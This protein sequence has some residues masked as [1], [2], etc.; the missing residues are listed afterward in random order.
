[1]KS[2]L[3]LL[4]LAAALPAT[5]Q[6]RAVPKQGSAEPLPFVG[7][8]DLTV[9]TPRNSYPDWL[10]VTGPNGD[11]KARYQPQG[12][13]SQPIRAVKVDAGRLILTISPAAGNRPEQVWEMTVDGDR[14]SGVQKSGDTETAKLEG[15]RAPTLKRLAPLAWTSPQPLFAGKDLEGW[16]P[17]SAN[18]NHWSA[19]DGLLVNESRGANLK[20]TRK[21]DDFKLHIELNCPDEHCNSGIFLRG[22]YEVQV[23]TEGGTL[24]SHEQGAIYG[25]VAPTPLL[26][27]GIGQWQVFDITL[28]G[29]YVTVIKNGTKIHDDV[30]IPGI[31][32]GALDA[33]EGEPGPF[34]LQGDHGPIAYRNITVSVPK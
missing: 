6:V 25:M 15:V 34:L 11:L 14:I 23:G 8:W 17:T 18:N 22:R 30:E 2:H 4:I 19:K 7:R 20:T 31:T 32:G 33:D 9:T 29:R 21:F 26:P 1:M 24:P 28:V 3:L 5:A 12:G 10:E 27:L 16:E 13:A